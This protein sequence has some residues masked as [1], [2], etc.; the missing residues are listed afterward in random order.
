MLSQEILHLSHRGGRSVRIAARKIAGLT[1][2]IVMSAS[3]TTSVASAQQTAPAQPQHSVKDMSLKEA[4]PVVRQDAGSSG[5]A[6][7]P[8]QRAVT[9]M[10]TCIER[11]KI[12]LN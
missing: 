2:G 12:A 7:E 6:V 11:L 5:T 10:Q 3:L 8:A 9:Q 4:C 1:A